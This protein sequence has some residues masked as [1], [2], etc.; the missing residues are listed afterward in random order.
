MLF[1]AGGESFL[2]DSAVFGG[3][4]PEPEDGKGEN[5]EENCDCNFGPELGETS[6][7]GHQNERKECGEGDTA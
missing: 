5:K 2:N 3:E 4:E 7:D 6:C 1:E